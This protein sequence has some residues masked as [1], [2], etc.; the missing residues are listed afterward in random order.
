ML[1]STHYPKKIWTKFESEQFK[2]R[3][4]ENKIIPI[5]YSDT[6]ISIF[7]ET[8][9]YGGYQFDVTPECFEAEA[10]EIVELIAKKI[11]ETRA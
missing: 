10:D 2:T 7:D 3:F 5:W 6:D 4:G 11:E 1:L 9:K 8:R